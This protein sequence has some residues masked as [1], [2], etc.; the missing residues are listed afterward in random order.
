MGYE[1]PLDPEQLAYELYFQL[2]FADESLAQTIAIELP[3]NEEAWQGVRERI[4]K[5][6][7]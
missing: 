5:A 3:P 2:R 6:S 4:L 7:I 1:L